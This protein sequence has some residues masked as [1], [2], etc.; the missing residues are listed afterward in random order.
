[1]IAFVI[2]SIVLIAMA[3]Y[4][5]SAHG[6]QVKAGLT[7]KAIKAK[8]ELSW[9]AQQI[10]NKYN[11]LPVEN[12]PYDNIVDLLSA[13]DV[14][15]G[16]KEADGHFKD[17]GYYTWNCDCWRYRYGDNKC[18]YQEYKDI[19]DLVQEIA[20]ALAEQKHALAVAQVQHHLED[21]KTLTERLR[22][23]KEI[24]TSVTKELT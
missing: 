6:K 15:H 5:G 17:Y 9:P 16:R 4:L 21:I 19:L 3:G 10:L 14:K 23:E 1:M 11:S 12:R 20:D 24:V 22:G 7:P 13:L 18:K 8:V 2:V